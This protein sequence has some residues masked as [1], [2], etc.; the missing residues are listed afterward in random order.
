MG[1]A[2]DVVGDELVVSMSSWDRIWTLRRSISVPTASV[3]RIDVAFRQ[4]LMEQAGLR[5][6]G[7]SIPGLILAGTYTVWSSFRQ[8]EGERQFWLVQRATEVLVIE[9]DLVRPSRL[10]VE[11]DDPYAQRQ[12]L[13]EEL[14]LSR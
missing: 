3:T 10:V 2:I 7:S 6:R 9:T 11:V 14:Q 12:R 13:N 4:P 8:H 1:V 5:V